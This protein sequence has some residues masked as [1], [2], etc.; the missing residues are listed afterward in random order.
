MQH[1]GDSARFD[2]SPYE[3]EIDLV[4]VDGA[5]SYQHIRNDTAAA[6]RMVTPRGVIVLGDYWRLVPDVPRFLDGLRGA[7]LYRI[8]GSRLVVWQSPARSTAVA[9]SLIEDT[10]GTAP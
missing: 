2:Y 3:R 9:A 7:D 10:A 5:H 4:Y 6:C 1:F 8:A